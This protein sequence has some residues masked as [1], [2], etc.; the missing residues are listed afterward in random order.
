M[1]LD[2]ALVGVQSFRV[3]P[4]IKIVFKLYNLVDKDMADFNKFFLNELVAHN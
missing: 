1:R 4:A 2:D 3:N